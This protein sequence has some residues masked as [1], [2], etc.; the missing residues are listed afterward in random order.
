MSRLHS[1]VDV[2]GSFN[3][4]IMGM[5]LLIM[6]SVAMVVSAIGWKKFI[7]FISIGYGYSIMAIGLAMMI[8][9][10]GIMLWSG[11]SCLHY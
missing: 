6:F 11:L 2:D 7:Y 4:S 9:H 3:L 5:T 10:H 1:Q 8:M